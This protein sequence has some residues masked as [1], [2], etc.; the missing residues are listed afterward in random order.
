MET[1]RKLKVWQ[2]AHQLVLETY[3]VTKHFPAEERYG[4]IQQMRRAA[5]SI[6]ANITEGHRRKSKQEFIQFLAIAHGSSD[7]LTYYCLLAHD[8][9]YAKGMANTLVTL[10]D[11]VGKML[12]GL[13][14]HIHK[15]VHHV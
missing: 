3:R 14:H 1:F 10:T 12:T 5:V 7:E 4:L 8:L 9:E 15:E 13:K 6:S 2:K 11:E